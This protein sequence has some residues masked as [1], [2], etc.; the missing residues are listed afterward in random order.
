M[1]IIKVSCFDSRQGKYIFLFCSKF[2]P[3]LV[4]PRP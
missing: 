2:K 3:D 4:P 1:S